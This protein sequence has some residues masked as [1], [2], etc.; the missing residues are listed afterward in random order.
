M[1]APR[2]AAAARTRAPSGT[3]CARRCFDGR[4]GL[5]A[6]RGAGRGRAA[7]LAVGT[8][9]GARR[10]RPRR[11]RPS[12]M[13]VGIDLTPQ[14]TA[15]A[16]ASLQDYTVL[17]AQPWA[18]PLLARMTHVRFWVDWPFVQPDGAI[19]L[20]DPAN[21]GPA[22]P[23]GA[24]RAGR[25]GRR[26]RAAGDPDAVPLSALGQP[27]T[28]STSTAALAGVADAALRPRPGQPWARFVE[29]LWLRYSCRM[30]C[31]EVVNEPNLQ[32]WPQ[33][34]RRGA[35]RGDDRDGRR[36]RAAPRPRRVPAWPRRS[37]TPS[38]TGRS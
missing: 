34:R 24:R 22:A 36:D 1:I 6:T 12:A 14:G 16:R 5:D 17:R 4:H 37:P 21:P 18:P 30:A 7:W 31:F 32:I 8:R 9:A 35:R 3:G 29:A 38:P 26:R 19:A 20:D 28:R 23:A 27:H 15:L 13:G 11:R 33:T 10:C 25:R 2:R